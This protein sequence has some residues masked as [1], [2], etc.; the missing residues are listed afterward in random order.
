MEIARISGMQFLN[1]VI[2]METGEPVQPSMEVIQ[3]M[4]IIPVISAIITALGERNK[5]TLLYEDIYDDEDGTSSD[6][7]L[8]VEVDDAD[9][10]KELLKHITQCSTYIEEVVAEKYA[11]EGIED[12]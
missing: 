8:V 5:V 11:R 4:G 2:D 1:S 10:D 3:N 12:E 7:L 9:D 6:G